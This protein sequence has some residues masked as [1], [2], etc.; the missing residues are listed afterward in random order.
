MALMAASRAL[1]PIAQTASNQLASIAATVAI[2]QRSGAG[3]FD[4]GC[5]AQI[6]DPRRAAEAYRRQ[7]RTDRTGLILSRSV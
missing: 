5:F 7:S 2:F 1:V 3:A 4:A 6:V